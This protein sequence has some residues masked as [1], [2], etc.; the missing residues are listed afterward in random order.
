[1]LVRAYTSAT[2]SPA[3]KA[4]RRYHTRSAFGLARW[5]AISASD[6]WSGVPHL[7]PRSAP[8]P[9]R[10]TSSPRRAFCRL[11]LKVRPMA[12]VSPTDFI[13]VVRVGSASGNFSKLNRGTFVTT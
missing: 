11:S 6:G 7:S 2:L 9:N 1:M 5:R 3:L 10:P 13:W 8:S 4:Y 12:I